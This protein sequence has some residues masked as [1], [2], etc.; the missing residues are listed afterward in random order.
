[1]EN[2]LSRLFREALIK[3]WEHTVFADYQGEEFTGKQVAIK[4]KAFHKLYDE[5]G[6]QKGEKIAIMGR[7]TSHWAISYVSVVT[8]GCVVV[9]ILPDFNK[10]EVLH[11]WEHSETVL[12]LTSDRIFAQLAGET[13]P[14]LKAVYSLNNFAVLQGEN[15]PEYAEESDIKQEELCYTP[16]DGNVLGVLSYTSGT[17]GFSKGVMLSAHN[18]Y[19][20]V[21]FAIDNLTLKEGG[22]VLSFLPLA[23]A[24][25]CAF[26]FLWP[27]CA[28]VPIHF[29]EKIPKHLKK[30]ALRLFLWCL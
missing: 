24:F 1:M 27:F 8:Y 15:L 9:P 21:Q 13:I 5:L 7:N 25:G 16:L 19:S 11:I 18:L 17:S 29:I 30:Y 6:I 14:K 10:D 23:H 22:K 20:N 28:G 26:E 3:G 12:A 4:V 2:N